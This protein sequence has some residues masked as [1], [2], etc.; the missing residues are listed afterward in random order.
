MNTFQVLNQANQVL[1]SYDT[2][3]ECAADMARRH[4][5]DS[6]GARA[7]YKVERADDRPLNSDERDL[8][9]RAQNG[10]A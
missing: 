6:L 1:A 9:W 7:V 5:A 3:E 2:L 10:R 4:R 8:L